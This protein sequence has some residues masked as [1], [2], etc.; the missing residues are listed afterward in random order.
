M[1]E[2]L[3][4]AWIGVHIAALYVLLYTMLYHIR[5]TVFVVLLRI[6]LLTSCAVF[7]HQNKAH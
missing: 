4:D 1:T 7:V 6:N 2:G 3:H 5:M